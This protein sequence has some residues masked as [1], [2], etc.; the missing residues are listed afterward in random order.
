[1]NTGVPSRE[2]AKSNEVP[3]G[4]ISPPLNPMTRGVPLRI[5]RRRLQGQTGT[6]GETHERDALGRDAL[7]PQLR[8]QIGDGPQ[9]RGEIRLVPFRWFEKGVRVPGI[10][11]RLRRDDRDAGRRNLPGKCHDVLGAAAATVNGDE[12][13]CHCLERRS[14][15]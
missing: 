9:R 12:G 11:G 2:P 10:P 14:A 6:L 8:D 4:P 3:G 13:A 5:A 7:L 15:P 1:M